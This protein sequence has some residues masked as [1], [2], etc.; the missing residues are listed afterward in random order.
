MKRKTPEQVLRAINKKYAKNYVAQDINR[1]K[2]DVNKLNSMSSAEKFMNRM[3]AADDYGINLFKSKEQFMA[4]Y[5]KEQYGRDKEELEQMYRDYSH[6][7]DLI[8]TGQYANY[9]SE[10][11]KRRY[12]NMA[13]Q[14]G[15][16]KTNIMKLRKL[17]GHDISDLVKSG[18]LPQLGEWTY[19]I[20]GI[21]ETTANKKTEANDRFNSGLENVHLEEEDLEPYNKYAD[22]FRQGRYK[23]RVTKQGREYIRGFSR[24][25]SDFILGS[26]KDE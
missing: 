20:K 14:S 18:L 12:I 26:R 15:A 22:R 8:D 25:I 9:R 3:K 24:F 6:R 17:S 2:V 4:Y 16:S 23:V 21:T 7:L 1:L 11:Y 19:P 10:T 5:G 13:M